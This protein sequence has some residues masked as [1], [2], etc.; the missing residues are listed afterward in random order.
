G[1][2]VADMAE[3]DLYQW[4]LA[5]NSALPSGAG[6]IT[7]TTGVYTITVTWDD[8]RDGSVDSNDPNFQTSF[9]L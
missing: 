7:V 6:T 1:C 3:N 8:N 2:S 5:V 9:K 4:N